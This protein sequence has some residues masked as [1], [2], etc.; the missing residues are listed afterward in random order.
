[1]DWS[2]K[3]VPVML[4]WKQSDVFTDSIPWWSTNIQPEALI[5]LAFIF[6]EESRIGEFDKHIYQIPNSN[7]KL[8]DIHIYIYIYIQSGNPEMNQIVHSFS[9]CFY[10]EKNVFN[11]MQ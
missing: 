3:E 7:T 10:F 5:M 6:R 8:E 9:N 1:M 11:N 4:K 2:E